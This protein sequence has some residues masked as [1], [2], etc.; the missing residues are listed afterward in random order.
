MYILVNLKTAYFG[1]LNSFP[2]KIFKKFEAPIKEF[3]MDSQDVCKSL[4]SFSENDSFKKSIEVMH[5]ID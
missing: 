1:M 3:S 4:K 2:L 5:I